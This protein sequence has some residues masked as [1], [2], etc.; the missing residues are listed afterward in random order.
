MYDNYYNKN[1]NGYGMRQID[2]DNII[3][4]IEL[5]DEISKAA[6]GEAQAYN[7][8]QR[9]AELAKSEQQRQVIFQVQQDESKHYRWFITFLRR[10]GVQELNIPAV[11][12]PVEF[13]AG[14]KMAIN[15][16]LN[17]ADLY[18][19][20]SYKATSKLVSLHFLHASHD[21]K[22]HAAAFQTMLMNL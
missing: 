12:L 11:E 15:N 14:L 10:L 17:A 2:L 19:N 4:D 9:L 5:V 1:R 3:S 13:E 20:I 6:I 8:Y 18:E 22:R 21:E 16:E 7:F